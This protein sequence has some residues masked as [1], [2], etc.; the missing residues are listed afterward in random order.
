MFTKHSMLIS[1]NGRARKTGEKL[2]RLL[3]E[4]ATSS[5]DPEAR[6]LFV[7]AQADSNANLE[8]TR[9]LEQNAKKANR[10]LEKE[11]EGTS[12]GRAVAEYRQSG[13][14]LGAAI[15]MALISSGLIW[16]S[17]LPSFYGKALLAALLAL[18]GGFVI[19]LGAELILH[20]LEK[21]LTEK[22]TDLFI[23]IVALFMFSSAV[24]GGILFAKA[25]ALQWEINQQT[26]ESVLNSPNDSFNLEK[27]K[28]KIEKLNS[29]GMIL[30]FVGLEFIAGLLAFK[31]FKVFRKQ[32]P[33]YTLIKRRDRLLKQ[34]A[35]LRQENAYLKSISME[36]IRD[37][38]SAGIERA[39]NKGNLPLLVFAI[40]I[41]VG[42]VL[43]FFFVSEAIAKER[44]SYYLVALDSTGSTERD[45]LENQRA[46]LRIIDSLKPCDEIQIMLITENTFSNPEFMLYE[47]MPSRAGYF[48]EEVRRKK[49]SL[50]N[51]FRRK[52]EKLD[53]ERPAT[54][55]I[56]GINMF[57]KMCREHADKRQVLVIFSD[58]RQ[59]TKEINEDMIVQRGDKVLTQLKAD[60]LVPDMRGI[61]VYVMGVSTANIKIRNWKKLEA[62]WKNFFCEAGGNLKCYDMGRHQKVN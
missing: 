24:G 61:E 5:V 18:G 34:I 42:M 10:E 11:K 45:N 7:K 37:D 56:D 21:S 27:A 52:T 20:Y 17:I 62:F 14:G 8:K 9:Y 32:K 51:E 30:L 36:A 22:Q 49:I 54:S 46:I 41:I 40:T 16:W 28:R 35:Q 19:F 57:A 3:G 58:M 12:E 25:R 13:T 1:K 55:L 53:I 38:I 60:N 48:N 29:A 4:N 15:T 2:Y 26:S 39:R 44:C 47:T 33:L 50:I 23:C 59:F 31:A 43:C 6:K